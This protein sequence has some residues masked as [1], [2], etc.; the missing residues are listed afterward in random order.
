M[1]HEWYGASNEMKCARC[2]KVEEYGAPGSET[3][4]CVKHEDL[5][6]VLSGTD[7]NVFALMGKVT[8]AMRHAGVDKEERKQFLE[9]VR[10]CMSYD[11]AIETM[12]GWVTVS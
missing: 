3:E 1:R 8:E 4:Q 6:V 9:E 11:E 2:K 10:A 5:Q 12:M 7:G